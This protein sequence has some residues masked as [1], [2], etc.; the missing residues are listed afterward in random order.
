VRRLVATLLVAASPAVLAA[1]VGATAAR[2][3]GRGPVPAV[4]AVAPAVPSTGIVPAPS[5]A[6]APPAARLTPAAPAPARAAAITAVRRTVRAVGARGVGAV[7]A[8]AKPRATAIGDA[9]Y[10][11]KLQ[12]ELCRARQIFCG[13]DHSGHYLAG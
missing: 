9:A 12:A 11:E 3:P 8:T 10:A 7:G 5:A 4:P 13:L 2:T 1:P 6:V